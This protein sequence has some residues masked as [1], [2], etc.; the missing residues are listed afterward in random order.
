MHVEDLEDLEEKIIKMDNKELFKYALQKNI[1]KNEMLCG[2]NCTNMKLVISKR[3][4]DG[5]AWRCFNKKC[6]NYQK[7]ISVRNKSNLEHFNIKLK[8]IFKILIKY[9][10]GQSRNS[11]INSMKISKPSLKKFLDKIIDLMILDNKKMKKLGGFE[12]IVQVDETMLNYK[13]KSH[14]GRSPLNK[15][16]A[17]VIVEVRNIV[18]QIYAQTIENK[19]STTIIPIIRD[20]VVSGTEIHTDEHKSYNKL[21]KYGYNHKKVCH[22]YN[23]INRENNCHTQHVES[24]NNCI[25]YHIKKRKGI[26]TAHREKFLSEFIWIWNNKKQLYDYI[27]KLLEV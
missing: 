10:S 22:K 16:D 24:I 15:T 14:R 11:I 1:I 17:L 8:T 20:H 21:Q 3:Y 4:V 23:F 7:R 2:S 19:K 27:I 25:K 18:T 9:S 5:Y 26:L 6:N 12:S 13:C